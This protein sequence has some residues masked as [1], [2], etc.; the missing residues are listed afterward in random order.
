MHSGRNFQMPLTKTLG[1]VQSGRLPPGGAQ[2]P[3][4]SLP[5]SADGGGAGEVAD[6]LVAGALVADSDGA[7][8]AIAAAV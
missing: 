4:G 8:D 5:Q 3:A 1:C 2:A 7:A 6:A